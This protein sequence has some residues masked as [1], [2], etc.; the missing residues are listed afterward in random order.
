MPEWPELRV[1]QERIAAALVGKTVVAVRLGDPIV[2]RAL[3]PVDELLVGRMLRAVEHHGKLVLFRFDETLMTVNPMLTGLFSLQPVGAK[4]TKDT[5]L[6]LEFEG[7]T[8]LRYRDD[9]RMGKVYVGVPA[10]GLADIGPDAGTLDWSDAEFAQR[11]KVKR[12]EVR[13]LL[14]DQSF[15]SGIGNAYADEILWDARLHPKR[16]I[17]SLSGEELDRLHRSLRSVIARGLVE[18]EA[19]MPLELG[20]KPRDHLR[21]RGRAGSACPRCG[22]ALMRR[23]K[24]LDDVDLCPTCQPAPKGQLY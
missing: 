24:G 4:V 22:T 18:V 19:G 15:V 5:R 20:K 12:S 23:R 10:P 6:R 3:R 13:N 11:A 16:R 9:V 17:G 14:Q 2:L 21:V 8:E 7:G 1:M